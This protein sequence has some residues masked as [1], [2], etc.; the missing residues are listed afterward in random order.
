MSNCRSGLLVL[1]DHM[2]IE[3]STGSAFLKEGGCGWRTQ[4]REDAFVSLLALGRF[5][6]ARESRKAA[7]RVEVGVAYPPKLPGRSWEPQ[8]VGEQVL[9]CVVPGQR[10]TCLLSTV[11]DL[12]LEQS[13]P[14]SHWSLPRS[15]VAH[16]KGS[17]QPPFPPP[18][19][20]GCWARS[21][22]CHLQA[23][24]QAPLP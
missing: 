16:G 24:T 11:E 8:T 9:Q 17:P 23:L 18:P 15:Q 12:G 5:C 7:V 4:D 20:C 10:P 14:L 19:L 13:E 22:L 2:S 6:C 3:S 21:A 1:S